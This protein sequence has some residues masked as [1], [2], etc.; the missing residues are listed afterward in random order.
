MTDLKERIARFRELREKCIFRCGCN[1]AALPLLDECL[2]RVE[3]L[4][5]ALQK[6]AEWLALSGRR[7]DTPPLEV[8]QEMETLCRSLNT[9]LH[10]SVSHE[11]KAELEAEIDELEA[12]NRKL[13]ERIADLEQQKVFEAQWADKLKE[14][15]TIDR[16][17]EAYSQSKMEARAAKQQLQSLGVVRHDPQISTQSCVKPA[18]AGGT[19]APVENRDSGR[20]YKQEWADVCESLH[21]AHEHV[22]KV[23]AESRK[24]REALESIAYEPRLCG[25]SAAVF[26]QDTLAALTDKGET[27]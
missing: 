7:K 2:S 22:A 9:H 3:E 11:C 5:T 17:I 6:G 20:D 19:E 24:L 10:N 21:C 13:S 23:E 8:V 4:E 18:S 25:S 27:E 16:L 12:E 14:F 15:G 1:E 26:A